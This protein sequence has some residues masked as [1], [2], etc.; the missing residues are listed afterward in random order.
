MSYL[1]YFL[2]HL[3]RET[4]N[5]RYIW[6][7]EEPENSLEYS[8]VQK[9]ADEFVRKFNRFAQIFLTT[10]SPAFVDLR[11][12]P[13]VGFYRAYIE[14]NFDQTRPNKRLTRVRTLADIESLQ[15]NL[16]GDVQ[17]EQEI[18]VLR[19]ELGMVEFSQEIERAA[20]VS[21]SP[22]TEHTV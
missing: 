14:P 2:A 16:L 11:H 1:A 18:E 10:H 4:P 21:P 3:C 19:R 6:G 8:K 20:Q 9:L 7:F 17:R 12:L 13:Q 15:L 22:Y 5:I